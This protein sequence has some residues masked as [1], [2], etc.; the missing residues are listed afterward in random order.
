MPIPHLQRNQDR[1]QRQAGRL[2][3]RVSFDRLG[4]V[5]MTE[6]V[7][8]VKHLPAGRIAVAPHLLHPFLAHQR[9][10]LEV[11]LRI[12]LVVGVASHP[13]LG[14]VF[15]NVFALQM[16][17]V[18]VGIA[19]GGF[20]GDHRQ[21]HADIA[22][23]LVILIAEDRRTVVADVAVFIHEIPVIDIVG[24]DELLEILPRTAGV[25][26][27]AVA[28]VGPLVTGERTHRAGGVHRLDRPHQFLPH[29]PFLH[30]AL[31]VGIPVN[32]VLVGDRP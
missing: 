22:A 15:A 5:G 3:C 16:P 9:D 12:A 10:V 18:P 30:P 31:E 6:P 1:L 4:V 32:M 25:L 28:I 7:G 20:L 29:P 21:P 11:R 19:R 2:R 17:G 27:G 26:A 8:A 23:V 13:R 24:L 14:H